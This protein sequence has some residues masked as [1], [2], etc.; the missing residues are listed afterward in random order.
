MHEHFPLQ[1]PMGKKQQKQKKKNTLG[2]LRSVRISKCG[3]R[4]SHIVFFITHNKSPHETHR[5]LQ[6][7]KRKSHG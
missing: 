2:L 1:Q 7:I 4:L 3:Q 5:A 6:Y